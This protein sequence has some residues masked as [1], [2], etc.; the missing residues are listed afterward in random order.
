MKS[1]EART[2]EFQMQSEG[3]S[4][5]TRG[6][7]DKFSRAPAWAAARRDT[8]T[9]MSAATRHSARALRRLAL[10]LV[11]LA[12]MVGAVHVLGLRVQHTASLPLGLYR[13]I[14]GAP[15][16]GTMGMWCL[17]RSIAAA[18]RTLGYLSAG[19]CVGG[20]EPIGK[21]VLG[22]ILFS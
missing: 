12:E 16:R 15:A 7:C 22:A 13:T 18:G 2:W 11:L 3:K 10:I 14:G 19:S 17:P 21:M 1:N 4:D 5:A 6:T 8:R 20:T 9:V